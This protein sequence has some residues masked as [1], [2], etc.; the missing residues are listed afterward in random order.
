MFPPTKLFL[1]HQK[2]AWIAINYM[3]VTIDDKLK[4]K[5]HT[6]KKANKIATKPDIKRKHSHLIPKTFYSIYTTHSLIHIE[7]TVAQCWEK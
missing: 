4:I 1:V 7:N 6:R 3:G 5:T 2:F